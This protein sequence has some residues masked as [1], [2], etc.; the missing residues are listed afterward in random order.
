MRTCVSYKAPAASLPSPPPTA[1]RSPTR[2]AVV[3]H[4]NQKHTG[5][6][7]LAN[8]AHP[9]QVATLQSHYS[10]LLDHLAL[11]HAPETIPDLQIKTVTKSCSHLT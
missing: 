11:M 2:M 1:L 6:G 3:A 9:N 7:I 4:P 5:N 10:P 8:V